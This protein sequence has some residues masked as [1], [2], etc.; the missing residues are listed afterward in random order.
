MSHFQLIV[1]STYLIMTVYLINVIGAT[2]ADF[3][4]GYDLDEFTL[5]FVNV[6]SMDPTSGQVLATRREVGKFGHG[7]RVVSVSGLLFDTRMYGDA[8]DDLDPRLWPSEPWIAF[9]KYGGGSGGGSPSS[10]GCADG[11][12]LKVLAAT[13]ATAALIYGNKP[14]SRLAKLY[15]KSELMNINIYSYQV[16]QL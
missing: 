6:T 2:G 9:V 7:A 1:L 12:Q 14:I 10:T 4:Y 3:A 13:N 8:C 11:Q 16:N 5:A 15:S